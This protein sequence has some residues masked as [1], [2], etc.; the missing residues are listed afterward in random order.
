M[1]AVLE[2][3]L[4]VFGLILAGY[5]FARL[6]ML[7]LEGTRGLSNFVYYVAIPALLFR[8]VGTGPL[9]DASHI[10]LILTYFLACLIVFGATLL[11]GRWVFGNDLAEQSLMGLSGSFSNTV[12]LGIPLVFTMFGPAGMLPLTLI[13]S[14]HSVMMLTLATVVIEVARGGG[15][16]ALRPM[17][18]AVA[19]NPVIVAILAGFAWHLVGVTLPGPALRF[20][21][22]LADG[23]TPCALFALGATLNSFRIGGDLRE[24]LTVV[25]IKLLALPA[26][27]W[28][29]ATKVFVLSPLDASVATLVAALPAGANPFILAQRYQ[30]YLA[31]SATV[32]VIS[33]VSSVVTVGLLVAVLGRTP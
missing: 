23:S 1:S 21:Q 31:R 33:T 13:I 4:P 29:L 2:V 5:G 25:A 26:L 32:V 20:L 24:S 3:V 10:G 14:F 17:L 16:G 27:V 22:L 11:L 15:R 8:G 30:I 12:Q 19:T 28:L 9:P 6:G 7:S 18:R